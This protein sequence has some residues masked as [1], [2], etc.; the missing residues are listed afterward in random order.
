MD[1]R[2]GKILTELLVADNDSHRRRGK[3]GGAPVHDAV[4]VAYVI[5]PTLMETSVVPIDVEL[6][7]ELTRGMT[8]ADFRSPVP[9]SC[10]TSVATKLDSARFWRTVTEAVRNLR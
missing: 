5:D 10:P 8:V 6:R 9:E 1:N 3:K 2:A 4:A 7:G